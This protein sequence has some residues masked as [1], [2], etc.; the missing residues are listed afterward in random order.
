MFKNHQCWKIRL[1]IICED[2]KLLGI[3]LKLMNSLKNILTV[4]NVLCSQE[5]E[6]NFLKIPEITV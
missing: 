1:N 2:S 6:V 5:A 3:K 4:K